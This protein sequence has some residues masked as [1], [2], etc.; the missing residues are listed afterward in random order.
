MTVQNFLKKLT[1][2]KDKTVIQ[3][4]LFEGRLY[5]KLYVVIAIFTDNLAHTRIQIATSYRKHLVEISN[6]K[7]LFTERGQFNVTAVRD[8][9]TADNIEEECLNDAVKCG[10]EDIEVFNAAERHVTFFCDPKNFLQVRYKLTL[11]GH[12]IEQSEC[13]FFPNIQ[14]VQLTESELVDYHKFK[15]RLLNVDGFDE[16]YDNLDEDVS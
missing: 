13:A 12:R 7:R 16:I 9:I 5:K 10:A 6:T 3:R 15:E 4:H 14:L 11:A 1:D 2:S 8:G